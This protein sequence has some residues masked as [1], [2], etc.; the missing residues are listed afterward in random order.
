[1]TRNEIIHA[2]KLNGSKY[3]MRRKKKNTSHGVDLK[4]GKFWKYLG[5]RLDEVAGHRLRL[6]DEITGRS[7]IFLTSDAPGDIYQS[8]SS[9]R[10]TWIERGG[11]SS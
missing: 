10:K 3:T 5:V 4:S 2:I 8:L 11:F 9:G 7:L 1:M 6:T